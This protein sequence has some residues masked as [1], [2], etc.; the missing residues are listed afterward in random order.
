MIKVD[1]NA[2]IDLNRLVSVEEL[3][4]DE[5]FY[6]GFDGKRVSHSCE[7]MASDSFESGFCGDKLYFL[8]ANDELETQKDSIHRFNGWTYACNIHLVLSVADFAKTM[9][10]KQLDAMYEEWTDE[11]LKQEREQERICP[12]CL[13]DKSEHNWEAHTAEMRATND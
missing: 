9:A 10:D 3:E 1:L 4:S 6:I 7:H 5:R 2:I 11:Q 13:C 12:I 8:Q